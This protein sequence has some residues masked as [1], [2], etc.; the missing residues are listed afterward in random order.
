MKIL[1]LI[2]ARGG[3]KRLPKKNVRHLGGKPLI[4]W[5]IQAAKALP[6]VIA[7]LVSTDDPEIATY[8]E[9]A[10]ALVLGLRPSELATDTALSVDVAIHALD[11]YERKYGPVDGLLL[12]QPTSPFRNLARLQAGLALFV[13]NPDC[14]VIGVSPVGTHPFWCFRLD[15]AEMRPFFEG[16]GLH[17]R[18]QDLPPAYA[19][20]GAFYL[21]PAHILR[22]SHS[23]YAQNLLPLVMDA[24]AE[25]IDIDTE[26]DWQA[27]E[28][29]LAAQPELMVGDSNG[30]MSG[31][32]Q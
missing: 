12:L 3:S 32:A 13:A 23:L 29:I 28:Q 19:I 4:V 14:S 9:D 20:N 8:A 2:P 10:G 1:A 7:A 30:L 21:A 17:L 15:G 22:E 6:E 31:G 18:S 27:A 26:Q 11:G 5:S 25:C 24:P 16:G